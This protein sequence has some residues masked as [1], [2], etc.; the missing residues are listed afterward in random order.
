MTPRY[1]LRGPAGSAKQAAARRGGG[2][3]GKPSTR[4]GTPPP[5][6][7]TAR[8]L[9][10]RAEIEDA[11]KELFATQGYF[12]TTVSDIALRAGRSSAAF[13]QY[14]ESKE[15]LLFALSDQFNRDVSARARIAP[16]LPESADDWQFS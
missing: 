12:R 10:G 1:T 11:A 13:Y 7:T 4:S 6:P 5:P 15:Q 3:G 8:G 16:I 9:R 2:G 14:F